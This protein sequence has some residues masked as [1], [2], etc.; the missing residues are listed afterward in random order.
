MMLVI[1]IALGLVTVAVIALS[2]RLRRTRRSARTLRERVRSLEA[3]QAHNQQAK[4][5]F[6]ASITHEL[7]T[8]L[9][10][11][12]GYQELLADGLYGDIDKRLRRP[13][14]QIGNAAGNLLQL[15]D[16]ILELTRL[17]AD[18]LELTIG[19][20]PVH[21]IL[22]RVAKANTAAAAAE[23]VTIELMDPPAAPPHLT[24]DTVRL[25]NAL[26]LALLAAVR[27]AEP[28]CV[29]LGSTT[30]RGGEVEIRI[31]GGRLA[32]DAHSPERTVGGFEDAPDGA[33]PVGRTGLRLSIARRLARR[34]GGELTV[35]SDPD[36]GTVI[37][38]RIS[39]APVL[40]GASA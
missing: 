15:I 16:G 1:S 35:E 9:T 30:T 19:S 26:G 21:Q 22:A 24:T 28:P 2:I 10:A 40:V 12:M 39:D 4:D 7:R 34:L 20:A 3:E 25:E 14:R 13:I 37:L 5:R 23:G 27:T 36:G 6:L 8:P 32:L 31:Y 17:D 38:V 18:R 11:I 29:R 33:E